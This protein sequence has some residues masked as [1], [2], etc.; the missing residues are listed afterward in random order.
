MCIELKLNIKGYQG[1]TI[2]FKDSYLLLPY[3]LR[4]LCKAFNVSSVKGW[5]PFNLYDIFYKGL[6]PAFN[7]WNITIEEYDS[8]I[9]KYT[10]LTWNFKDEAIK[11]CK[12]DCACLYQILNI[13]NELVYN[14]FKINIHSTLT[15]PALA[16]R[17]FKTHFMNENSI[18][19]LA[20]R[21]ERDI[22]ESYTGGAVDVYKPHN[23]IGSFFSNTYRKLYYYDVNSLYPTVMANGEMPIG[24]PIVFEG[25]IRAIESNAY[26]FFYC[27]IT[28]PDNLEHP[29]L[30]RKIETSEG[31]RTIA[32]LGTWK[33]WISSI[34]MDNAI[35]KGYTFKILKGY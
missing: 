29:I 24:Q 12:L 7:Y 19:Q 22:R 13:F 11:Y 21:I 34:E 20:G 18:Y 6:L 35:K 25:D 14:K 31:I 30:Q 2:V 4:A 9:K 8:L 23:K 15:L 33:G 10:G 16:M 26:G 1:K 28:S 17:I 3:S 32:G 5:F 27:E